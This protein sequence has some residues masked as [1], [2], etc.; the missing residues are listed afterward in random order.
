M[1]ESQT[2]FNSAD[3]NE[4]CQI[5]LSNYIQSIYL[6][7]AATKLYSTVMP[8]RLLH[9]AAHEYALPQQYSSTFMIIPNRI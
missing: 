6:F 7:T 1:P 4:K 2:S 3:S 8:N 5:K 9:T